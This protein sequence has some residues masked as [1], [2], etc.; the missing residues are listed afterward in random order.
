MYQYTYDCTAPPAPITILGD[1]RCSSHS[2][3]TPCNV[4]ARTPYPSGK[5]CT[6]V[7]ID[8]W[9][10]ASMYNNS[11]RP[12]LCFVWQSAVTHTAVK[13]A[14]YHVHDNKKQIV[15]LLRLPREVGSY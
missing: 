9:I 11:F 15:I 5:R 13:E 1:R 14:T 3:V 4:S 2:L 8:H 12:F 10:F 7:A 6:R